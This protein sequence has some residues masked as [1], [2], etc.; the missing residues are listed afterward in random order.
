MILK[1]VI[2]TH[3][4]SLVGFSIRGENE[5]LGEYKALL[6][7]RA[8]LQTKYNELRKAMYGAKGKQQ[9]QRKNKTKAKP[10][11]AEPK[12][13]EKVNLPPKPKRL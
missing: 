8:E 13:K 1:K 5:R 3:S 4:N 11:N 2:I 6:D 10:E 9:K 7:Q 12:K